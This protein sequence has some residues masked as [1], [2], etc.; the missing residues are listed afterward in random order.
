MLLDASRGCAGDP[1]DD[2]SC[3][4][5]NYIF[6][7]LGRPGAWHSAFRDLWLNFWESYAKRRSDPELLEVCAPFLAWRALLLCNPLLYPD[8]SEKDRDR[9][10]SFVEQALAVRRLDLSSADAVFA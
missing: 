1:A 4:A 7:A 6:F 5:I 10:L 9:L 3:M 8:V 2:V